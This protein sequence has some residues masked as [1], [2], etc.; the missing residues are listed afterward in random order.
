M[1]CGTLGCPTGGF[2]CTYLG[3]P[4]TLRKQTAVQLQRIVDLLARC[5]P[6]WKAAMMPKSGRLI[7]I[8][9]VLCSIPIH[10]ML[11]LDLPPKTLTALI[12]ICRG[13][14]WCGK[15]EA[16]GGNCAVAWDLVCMPKWAGGLDI[17]NLHGLNKALRARW[18]WLQRSD[19][20]KP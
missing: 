13:F 14:L 10:S 16:N 18:P 9:F 1:V 2:P 17:P 4:Q 12:K 7:L 6:H 19:N 3:L 11:A 20:S 5:L 15:Q 8:T